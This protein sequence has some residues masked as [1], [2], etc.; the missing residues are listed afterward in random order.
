MK[1][2]RRYLLIC[3]GFYFA[4]AGI[5]LF[6]VLPGDL[7]AQS[8]EMPAPAQADTPAQPKPQAD[9]VHSSAVQTEPSAM[10][11]S[12]APASEQ[13]LIWRLVERMDT[14]LANAVVFLTVFAALLPILV[15]V[16]ESHKLR[17]LEEIR[18]KLPERVRTEVK[19]RLVLIARDVEKQ[20][21]AEITRM[22]H[23]RVES[24]TSRAMTFLHEDDAQAGRVLLAYLN[25]ELNRD[26]PVTPGELVS[27]FQL[28]RSLRDLTSNIEND[29]RTA[30][31]HIRE[32]SR[33]I[34][35]TTAVEMLGYLFLAERQCRIRTPDCRSQWF[36]LTRD[37]RER[38]DIPPEIFNPDE[39]R[40]A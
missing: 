6:I 35:M 17:E 10:S 9:T 13:E 20:H 37:L 23:D 40:D 33:E 28:Q 29:V 38:Y 22:M 15:A 5:G 30:L 24:D 2:S 25:S 32:L 27:L 14:K 36:D 31:T 1:R 39:P 18:E 16:Y 12:A 3:A 26:R 8:P 34:T 21:M 4:F 11:P 19:E 7:R